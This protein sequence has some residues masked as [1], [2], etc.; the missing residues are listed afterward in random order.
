MII[1]GVPMHVS[2][3]NETTGYPCPRDGATLELLDGGAWCPLCH[4]VWLEADDID[5]A[6]LDALPEV[7]PR[8]RDGN[9]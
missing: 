6:D 3:G 5:L 8:E 7:D 9:G 4:T 2:I 1:P